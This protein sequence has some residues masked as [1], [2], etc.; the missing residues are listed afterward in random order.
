MVSAN[1]QLTLTGKYVKTT[2]A[3]SISNIHSTLCFSQICLT[4]CFSVVFLRFSVVVAM[5]GFAVVLCS[6]AA[7]A[8]Q[9]LGF[10]GNP[11][12]GLYLLRMTISF[13]V[14]LNSCITSYG[15]YT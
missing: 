3:M 7:A 15:A 9:G 5:V 8:I 13:L 1:L 12:V 6:I 4:L 10:I 14:Y 2:Q 11:F